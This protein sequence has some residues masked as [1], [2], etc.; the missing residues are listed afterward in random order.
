[1][2][3]ASSTIQHRIAYTTVYK[4]TLSVLDSTLQDSDVGQGMHNGTHQQFP[5]SWNCSC[6][7]FGSLYPAQCL[8]TRC[9]LW[10]VELPTV[11]AHTTAWTPGLHS[12]PP[13]ACLVPTTCRP[14]QQLVHVPCLLST[15]SLTRMAISVRNIKHSCSRRLNKK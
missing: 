3:C 15:N 2:L 6:P 1:M 10:P 13:S 5:R 9:R 14:A 11:Q 8:H 4:C 12:H 7:F